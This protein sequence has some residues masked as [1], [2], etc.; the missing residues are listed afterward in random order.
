M[1]PTKW[2]HPLVDSR[3][4]VALV[5]IGLFGWALAANPGDNT[6]KGALIGALNL[7][8]GYYLGSSRGAAAATETTNKAIDL[9]TASANNSDEPKKVEVTNDAEN[10]VQTHD[11]AKGKG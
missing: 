1:T 7:A 3:F 9:A 11:T 2:W 8:V 4:L 5:V 10:P 6:M